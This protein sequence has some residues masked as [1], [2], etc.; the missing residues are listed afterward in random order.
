MN[1]TELALIIV[2]AFILVGVITLVVMTRSE[3]QDVEKQNAVQAANIARANRN[4]N[5]ARRVADDD[6]GTIWSYPVQF[7]PAY[8]PYA[9]PVGYGGWGWRGWRGWRWR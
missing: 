2:S 4:A 1:N 8:Y 9:R 3:V 6:Y 7:A 5:I